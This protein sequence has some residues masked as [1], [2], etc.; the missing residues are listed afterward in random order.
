MQVKERQPQTKQP[1]LNPNTESPKVFNYEWKAV[2]V[3]QVHTKVESLTP[4][5]EIR[6][7]NPEEFRT[8]TLKICK[9][10]SRF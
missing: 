7:P 5:P 9:P 4:Q 2:Q 3:R 6:D 10:K 8:R 1:Q